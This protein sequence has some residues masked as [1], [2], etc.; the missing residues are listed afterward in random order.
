M[1][2]DTAGPPAQPTESKSRDLS[3]ESAVKL[4]HDDDDKK[5][6]RLVERLRGEFEHL[7]KEERD[8]QEHHL[9]QALEFLG[10]HP[11]NETIARWI[12][13][14]GQRPDWKPN[15]KN[16]WPYLA[17]ALYQSLYADHSVRP[18]PMD[19]DAALREAL[20]RQFKLE[21][22]QVPD[23]QGSYKEQF[24]RMEDNLTKLIEFTRQDDVQRV[25][26]I[27]QRKARCF[28][29]LDDWYPQND[30]PQNDHPPN[31]EWISL[32]K[33][34][35]KGC[36]S[37]TDLHREVGRLAERARALWGDAGVSVR[38]PFAALK[39]FCIIE[40][41]KAYCAL[42]IDVT[43][44]R[45][46]KTA[47]TEVNDVQDPRKLPDFLVAA[48]V[49]FLQNAAGDLEG[50]N[51]GA[52]GYRFGCSLFNSN[53]RLA[54]TIGRRPKGRK[55][56]IYYLKGATGDLDIRKRVEANPN[57]IELDQSGKAKNLCP[58]ES[59]KDLLRTL[60]ELTNDPEN[61]FSL[62][63]LWEPVVTYWLLRGRLADVDESKEGHVTA[64]F[65]RKRGWRAQGQEL[66]YRIDEREQV[67]YR[68]LEFG[69]AWFDVRQHAIDALLDDLLQQEK[70]RQSAEEAIGYL[71]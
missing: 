15:K 57:L 70:L 44:T 4:L 39:Y 23:G 16:P 26:V 41:L 10:E 9:K 1:S 36:D 29:G 5:V 46:T 71:L 52:L 22:W 11:S 28:P 67:F 61:D 37:D 21:V 38:M 12:K 25:A 40:F 33:R 62:F 68:L 42:K 60:K 35:R 14:D 6:K 48:A 66:E 8:R 19:H 55:P 20:L 13:H 34:F 2:R 31:A 7:D 64:V 27:E 58:I 47:V 49:T 63:S 45:T 17:F 51:C 30:H 65:V 50:A 24:S 69:A 18:G 3:A 56:T 54:Y 43:L 59:T 53:Q 32:L